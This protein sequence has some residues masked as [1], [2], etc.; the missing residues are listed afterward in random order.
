MGNVHTPG[1]G[2]NVMVSTV[3][4]PPRPG[5][6]EGGREEQGKKETEG[7]RERKERR[8]RDGVQGH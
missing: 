5:G 6:R 8:K 4:A 7:G 2:G 3:P 1:P